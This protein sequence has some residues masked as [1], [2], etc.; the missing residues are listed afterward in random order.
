MGASARSPSSGPLTAEGIASHAAARP[1][2]RRRSFQ[3]NDGHYHC[4]QMLP[5]RSLSLFRTR[6]YANLESAL[7]SRARAVHSVTRSVAA[8]SLPVASSL[9]RVSSTDRGRRSRTRTSPFSSVRQRLQRFT[10][11][12]ALDE[13]AAAPSPP[14][15]ALG[16]VPAFQRTRKFGIQ[17][18]SKRRVCGL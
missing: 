10:S 17:T 6:N 5:A 18:C 2:C 3:R 4:Q 12:A 13:S 8:L 1:I 7:P 14:R 11:S 16:S 9:A 15:S